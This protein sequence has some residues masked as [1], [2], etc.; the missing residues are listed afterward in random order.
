MWTRLAI[1]AV[2][3]TTWLLLSP[4][5]MAYELKKAGRLQ[6][7]HAT[8]LFAFSTDPTIQEVLSQD[9]SAA[10]RAAGAG[11]G[12]TLTVSVNV[13]QQ[14]LK[15]GISLQD[16]APGDPQ[17]ADLVAAAGASPPPV[18]DTGDQYDEAALARRTA[19]QDLMPRDTAAEQMIHSMSQPGGGSEGFGL[20]RPPIPLPCAAQTVARPGCPPVPAA[21][22]TSSSTD[23]N[24]NSVGDIKE[25]LDRKK[26]GGLFGPGDSKNYD[27]VV[28]ARAS[29]SGAKEEMTLVA[30]VHPGEDINDV[31]K[32]IAEEIAN[33]IL[34]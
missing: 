34:R 31:K 20:F 5:G 29:A 7:P 6:V 1:I 2:T 10:H 15:P 21:S 4:P 17:V 30:I 22:A 11:S 32:E 26:R 27:T 28:V 25:Y 23:A 3:G 8:Q 14:M 13:S 33:A 19:Q 12:P 16:L 9:F 24:S 18:G